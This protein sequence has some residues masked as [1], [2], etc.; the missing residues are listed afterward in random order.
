[1]RYDTASAIYGDF[2]AFYTGLVDDLAVVLDQV[3]VSTAS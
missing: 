2:G 1:M 3:G